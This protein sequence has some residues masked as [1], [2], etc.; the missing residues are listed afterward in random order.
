M[1]DI[2]FFFVGQ[3]V[4][5]TGLFVQNGTFRPKINKE[6][7]ESIYFSFLFGSSAI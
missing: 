2:P 6:V 3:Q 5:I 7:L 1:V 4:F